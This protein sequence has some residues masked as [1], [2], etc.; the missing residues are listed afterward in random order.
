MQASRRNYGRL[1]DRKVCFPF[2]EMKEEP[3]AKKTWFKTRLWKERIQIVQG[4]VG[5]VKILVLA[6]SH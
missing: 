6:K 2:Q 1:C 3:G 5:Q 4:F